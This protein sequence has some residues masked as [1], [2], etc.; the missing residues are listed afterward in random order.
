MMIPSKG[1]PIAIL[2]LMVVGML[3]T[4]CEQKELAIGGED[5]DIM[6]EF[7][8][9]L[10]PDA[11]PEGMTL[12]F[13]P[14]DTRSQ[15]WRFDIP[16]RDGGPVRLLSG[17]YD[18]IAY[19]SDLP[20]VDFTDTESFE[21]ISATARSISDSLSS[22]TGMLY[23]AALTDFALFPP[24]EGGKRV[25]RLMPESLSTLYRIR[26]DSVSGTRRIKTATAVLHGPARSVCLCIPRNSTE[27]CRLS[28]PL[29]IVEGHIDRLETAATGF[30][31]PPIHDPRFLLDI[32]VTTSHGR[33][34]KTFDVTE[35]VVNCKTPANVDIHIAGMVI[36]E[37][38]NPVAPGDDVGISVGVDGWQLIEIIYS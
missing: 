26:I 7:D 18:I 10:A 20:G 33:Y 35:Q 8:W 21:S 37:S 5:M 36:P 1:I 24:S 4:A 27:T 13:F 12:L 6:V 9:T 31:I 28:A 14:A 11:N 16:G 17:F 38:D 23:S 32:V 30:G 25:I 34:S 22:P 15:S 2:L 29:H 19:N 3:L